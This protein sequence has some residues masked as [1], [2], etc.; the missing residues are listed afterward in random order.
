[1]DTDPL[2]HEPDAEHPIAW[3][4]GGHLMGYITR[5]ALAARHER[6]AANRANIYKP[7]EHHSYASSFTEWPEEAVS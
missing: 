1:M 4:Y 3:Y 2:R 6:Y 5:A 7:G